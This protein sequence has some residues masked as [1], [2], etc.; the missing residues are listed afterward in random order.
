MATEP[1]I[2]WNAFGLNFYAWG[3]VHL[4]GRSDDEALCGAWSTTRPPPTVDASEPITC[5]ECLALE[6]LR[7]A[8]G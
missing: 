8:Q 5:F 7:G 3:L 4:N 1:K 6:G 2:R